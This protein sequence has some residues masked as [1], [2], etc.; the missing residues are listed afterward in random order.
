MHVRKT[1]AQRTVPAKMYRKV[2]NAI[3]YQDSQERI[4][5][6]RSVLCNISSSVSSGLPK[7][8]RESW[9]FVVWYILTKFEQPSSNLLHS[10]DFCCFYLAKCVRGNISTT[11]DSVWPHSQTLRRKS[12][13]PSIF[14]ALRGV[15]N[16]IQTLSRVFDISSQWKLISRR[17][18]SNKIIK[19][20]AN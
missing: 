20:C 5:P 16:S 13:Q 10:C 18:Q 11:T 12:E 15:W 4:A 3:V 9:K 8:R 7:P 14:D 6:V 17:Q 2:F 1:L 19:I